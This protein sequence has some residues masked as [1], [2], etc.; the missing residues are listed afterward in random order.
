MKNNIA[1]CGLD[2]AACPAYIATQADDQEGLKKTAETWSKELGLSI[3]PEDCIC[4]GCQPQEGA[5]LGGYCNECPVRAC[6]TTKGYPNCAYCPDYAC[7]DL[8]HFLAGSAAAKEK[9]NSI[10]SQT[11]KD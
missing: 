4:D 6:G 5:R 8:S 9:L 3:K 7:S 2:C 1:F 10:R 11:D